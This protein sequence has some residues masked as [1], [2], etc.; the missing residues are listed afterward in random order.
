MASSTHAMTA[1]SAGAGG[2]SRS[3]TRS[4]LRRLRPVLLPAGTAV[5]VLAVWEFIVRYN[6]IPPVV[7]PAPSAVY[8][9]IVSNFGLLMFHAW[10][11]ASEAATGLLLAIGFGVSLG[12]AL[13]YS[14]LLRDAIFPNLVFF[15]IIP[16]VALAPLFIMWLG[17]GGISRLAFALFISFFPIVISTMTGLANV[18]PNVIRMCRSLT[19]TD[20]QIFLSVR[21]PF[22]LPYV[23]NGLKIG[24]TMAM[25]GVIVGEFITSQAGL[26][27]L[28]LFGSSQADTPVIFA[29]IT[30]LCI[31][32]LTFY[33][34][35][36]F[37][38]RMMRR[39]F[40][41]AVAGE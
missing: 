38:D 41:G 4:R 25:I 33:G 13:T 12:M 37:A 20:W 24:V 5:L 36:A 35:V 6:H 14:P 31:V 39:W 28:I 15:Q 7:L 40:G 21:F 19:A 18:D 9:T 30:V 8:D 22:A 3:R 16:K 1:A 17:I 32:G 11:T 10:Q 27:Y 23:F 26:G 29:A 2:A 34:V